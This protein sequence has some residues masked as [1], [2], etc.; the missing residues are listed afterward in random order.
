MSKSFEPDIFE[1][2]TLELIY[3][4]EISLIW[5][6]DIL[7][8]YSGDEEKEFSPVKE[9][10]EYFWLNLDKLNAWD[11][12]GEY[13]DNNTLDGETW[14]LNIIYKNN[15][16]NCSGSNKYPDGFSDFRQQLKILIS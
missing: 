10:W 13:K 2:S 16:I 14:S 9:N 8:Y 4:K 15:E 3:F 1:F 11:W 5:D 12:Q 7:V 6:E